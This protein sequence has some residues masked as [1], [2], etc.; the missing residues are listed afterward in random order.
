[1]SVD[2]TLGQVRA[3]GV[4]SLTLNDVEDH[5]SRE[6]HF[7]ALPYPKLVD[8]RAAA[9]TFTEGEFHEFAGLLR[10]LGRESTLGNAT[11]LVADDTA[12]GL[13][14]M[15]EALVEEAFEVKPFRDE[16][17]ARAWFATQSPQPR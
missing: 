15:I 1:M 5:L 6:G 9:V 14:R 11:V 7:Q 12:F 2:H 8:L 13:A 4:G 17:E 16:E 10:R 3:I